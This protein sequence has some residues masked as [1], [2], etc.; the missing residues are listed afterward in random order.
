MPY[1]KS[2]RRPPIDSATKELMSHVENEGDLNYAITKMLFSYIRQKGLSYSI[3]NTLM[4]VLSCVSL[5]FYRRIVSPYEDKKIKENGD[6][7]LD[8]EGIGGE[9]NESSIT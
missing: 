1:I 4:G 3:C 8:L 2:N 7:S 6:I 5:E 9:D